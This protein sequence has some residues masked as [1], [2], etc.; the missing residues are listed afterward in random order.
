[1]GQQS[2]RVRSAESPA[3]ISVCLSFL[4]WAYPIDVHTDSPLGLCDASY[5]NAA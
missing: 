3:T 5:T 2:V 1:M 4:R